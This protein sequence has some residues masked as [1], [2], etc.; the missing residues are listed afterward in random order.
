[1]QTYKYY[2]TEAKRKNPSA[3]FSKDLMDAAFRVSVTRLSREIRAGR[4][5]DIQAMVD[6]VNF[7]YRV[8]SMMSLTLGHSVSA[9]NLIGI[10]KMPRDVECCRWPV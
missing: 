6:R 10:G 7:P 1:M 2:A 8:A 9:R 3:S 4:L 5:Q